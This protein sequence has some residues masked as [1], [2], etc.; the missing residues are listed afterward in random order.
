M[1]VSLFTFIRNGIKLGYPFV[2][3]I[4]S[5]LPLADEYIIALGPSDPDER[6][7]TQNAIESIG[8]SKIRIV[9]VRWNERMRTAGFVYGQQK[10]LAQSQC[11][12]D[13]AFYLEADEV[14]H[15]RQLDIIQS[16]MYRHVNNLSVEALIFDYIHFFGSP[17]F[18]AVSPGWYRRAPRIIR[19]SIRAFAADGL[20]WN[21]M[22]NNRKMRWPHAALAHGTIYHY[23]HVRPISAMNRKQQAVE[24]Y[25]SKTPTFIKQYTI[26]P[27]AL[28]HFSGEHPNVMSH[29]LSQNTDI[30]F[31]PDGDYIPNQRDKRHRIGM[32]IEKFFGVDL[33]RKHYKL[34]VND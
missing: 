22:I 26:D 4:K 24:Q 34:I 30:S 16:S 7:A 33:S 20:F 25:W 31:K 28:R 1:K 19:N 6:C 8:S 3:S 11:N 5:A 12:G 21:V 18:Q 10:M 23:G 14:L 32:T 15:E 17:K 9:N 13:W 29:W 2:E 27:R